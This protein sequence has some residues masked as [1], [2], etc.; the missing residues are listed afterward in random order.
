MHLLVAERAKFQLQG[1]FI[2][3]GPGL[4]DNAAAP[5]AAEPVVAVVF[6]VG[7]Q[8][9]SICAVFA[10]ERNDVAAVGEVVS[11]AKKRTSC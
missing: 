2:E 9:E 3:R 7:A 1:E 8:D 11:A 6:G 4:F 10:C 5:D